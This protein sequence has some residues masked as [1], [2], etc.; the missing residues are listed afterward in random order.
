MAFVDTPRMWGDFMAYLLPNLK[1]KPNIVTKI[2]FKTLMNSFFYVK[3][4]EIAPYINIM[5]VI[6]VDD[7]DDGKEK[8]FEK[9]YGEIIS[10]MSHGK[11]IDYYFRRL[12]GL[13]KILAKSS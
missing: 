7:Y 8:I 6:V 12:C 4:R 10:S 2:D 5:A 13:I 1:F 3:D 9:N 11:H